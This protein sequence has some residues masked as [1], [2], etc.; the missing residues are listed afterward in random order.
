MRRDRASERYTYDVYKNETMHVT[1]AF[2]QFACVE[3]RMLRITQSTSAEASRSYYSTADYYQEGQELVG[4]WRGIGAGRLGLSGRIMQRDWDSLCDNRDPSTGTTLTLRRK[5]NRRPGYDFNFHVPKSVSL[6]YGLTQDER[7]LEAFRQS[8]DETMRDMEAEMQT[9]VRKQGRDEDRMT[10]NMVWGEFIH[11]TSRPVDGVPDPHLHAHCYVFNVTYDEEERRWKAGQFAGIKRDGPYFEALFH[12]R[13]A[14]RLA[15]LGLAIERR[16]QRWEIAGFLPETL[17]KFS[18]RSAQIESEARAQRIVDPVDKAA[19]GAKT[20]ERKRN[21]LSLDELRIQW[22]KRLSDG[23]RDAMGAAAARIGGRAFVSEPNAA[24]AARDYAVAHCFE[25]KSVV[26]ERELLTHA[27]LHSAGCASAG[28]VLESFSQ[29]DFISGKRDGRNCFTT[30]EVLGEEQRMTG[31]ARR[32]RGACQPFA[33]NAT[34]KRAWLNADQRS[35]VEHVLRSRDRVTLVRGAAGVG[36]TSMMQEA[37]EAIEAA[38][39]KVFAFAPSAKASRGVLRE[40]GF[41]D[42]DTVARLLADDSLQR[43]SAGQAWWIDEAGLLGVRMTARLFDLAEKLH[44]RIILSG[45]RK[46]H[47]AVERGAALRLLEEE[48]GLVPADIKDIQ[49]QKGNYKQAVAALSE[50]RT[51]DGF[52]QL[53]AL[54]WIR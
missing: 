53:D 27:L 4:Q 35:A 54:G 12:S 36:K 23:E 39:R 22:Q 32:G 47:G 5:T 26:P 46:Q 50:G 34:I 51:V 29:H 18:R 40:A 2:P 13:L 48:S 8:V 14:R 33:A 6:L 43:A 11:L 37:V 42:A 9:R 52:R 38:G 21:E 24:K 15:E 41:A 1:F 19:L 44:A 20:R 30:R 7:L 3:F 31:F 16:A 25:R 49:R 10:G 45:D 17:A 28:A